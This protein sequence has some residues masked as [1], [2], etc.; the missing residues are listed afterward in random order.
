MFTSGSEVV[1]Q[2]SEDSVEPIVQEGTDPSE[3]EGLFGRQEEGPR[4][5][6]FLCSRLSSNTATVEQPS[7]I[8]ED[9]WAEATKDAVENQESFVNRKIKL[10][11]SRMETSCICPSRPKRALNGRLISTFHR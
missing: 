7:D 1:V 9:F 5:C 10:G 6:L 8:I 11:H 2:F 4:V 3:I